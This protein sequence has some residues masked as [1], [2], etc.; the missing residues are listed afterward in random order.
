M[1]TWT[2]S[3]PDRPEGV[4]VRAP[5]AWRAAA[6]AAAAAPE[7]AGRLIRTDPTRHRVGVSWP[8]TGPHRP[9]QRLHVRRA[10]RGAER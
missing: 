9:L 10:P 4:T 6:T 8:L 7:L 5:N 2:V 3:W 1:A